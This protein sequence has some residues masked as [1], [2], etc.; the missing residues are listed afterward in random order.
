MKV[1]LKSYTLPSSCVH[2]GK[3]GKT[4]TS[5]GGPG[6][7]SWTG[8]WKR[9]GHRPGHPLAE[10]REGGTQSL[11]LVPGR[12]ATRSARPTPPGPRTVDTSVAVAGQCPLP[13]DQT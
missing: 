1:I 10:T 8:V 7:S 2:T 6:S 9:P 11:P 4:G 5:F 13:R 12:V 3:M